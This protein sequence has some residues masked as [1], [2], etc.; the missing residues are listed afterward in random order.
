MNDVPVEDRLEQLVPPV[1]DLR[2]GHDHPEDQ[3]LADRLEQELPLADEGAND[4]PTG[5][6]G[7][8]VVQIEDD[9]WVPPAPD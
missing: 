9:E 3:P 5:F 4:L 8:R 2:V 6:D 7:D 1:H